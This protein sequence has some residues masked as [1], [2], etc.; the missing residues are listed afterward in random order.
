MAWCYRSSPGKSVSSSLWSACGGA[1]LLLD[2]EQ[3]AVTDTAT[4]TS[5]YMGDHLGSTRMQMAGAGWPASSDTFYPFGLEQSTQPDANHY[6]FTGLERDAESSLDHTAFRQYAYLQGRW[7]SPD[8]YDGSYDLTNPQSFNRYSYA[9]NNPL[10]F[11]DPSGLFALPPKGLPP[12]YCI[13]H[14][15]ICS[16][17]GGGGGSDPSSGSGGGGPRR[18]HA[19]NNRTPNK[20]TCSTVLPNGRTVGSYVNQLSNSINGSAG[21]PVSTPYGPGPNPSAPGPFSVASQVYSGTNFKIIFRG[22]G[23]A[24]FLGDAGNFAYAAVSGNIGVP[25]WATEAVAGGDALWAGHQDANGPWWMDA[26]ATA[27]VPAG[28]SAGCKTF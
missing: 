13:T 8:P 28:Y 11:T 4:S 2:T 3:T 10:S 7:T 25:L 23:N 1:N 14:P 5:Y 24:A 20:I 21:N 27:Q 26:S 18:G 17:L 9:L 15:I 12:G 6:K 22:Q 19:P 16:L